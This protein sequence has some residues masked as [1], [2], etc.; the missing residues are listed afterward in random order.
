[1]LGLARGR[2]YYNLLSWYRVLA[3]L[4]GFKLNRR[5]M[6][7]MMG[8][9]EGL[10]AAA[11]RE[12]EASPN[13]RE[14]LRDLLNL[15]RTVSGLVWNHFTLQRQI[16]AFE[17][18]LRRTLQAPPIPLEQM[19]LDE[20]SNYYR[21]L[22][23]ELLL[24][25]DAPLVNDFFAM[26]F[27]GL[28]RDMS[29][30]WVKDEAGT[31]PNDLLSGEGG[32]ISTEPARRVLKMA[33]LARECPELVTAL[34]EG[35][36]RE[37]IEQIEKHPEFAAAY[38]DYL[39][40]FGERCLE[41]LKLETL[42]LTDNPLP[43]L[44]SVGHAARRC[45]ELSSFDETKLR[46]A[47]EKRVSCS[48]KKRFA[49]R[50]L[51]DW[52]LQHARARVKARENLRFERTR[53]F[54][55]VRRIVVEM[56][57]RLAGEGR[58]EEDRDVFYL[59]IEELLGFVEGTA[60]SADLRNLAALRKKE[61]AR[62]RTEP[63]PA[64]RFE[65]TG[66]VYIG[67]RFSAAAKST[68]LAENGQE[69]RGIGCC[70]GLVRGK[71]RVILDPQ[72]A[73]IQPGEILVAPRTDPGWILLFPAAAGLLVEHGS[74]LSHSAIVAREMGIPAIVSIGGLTEWV[75]TGEWLEMDGATGL[76]RKISNPELERS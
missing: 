3:L 64:D 2:I 53:V 19:R 35:E 49:R 4:P 74:L 66:A 27:F 33:G 20:L 56:G 6:E 5:F 43:L 57:R 42:T 68:V 9:K 61:F 36:V 59:T 22:E 11:L 1:M 40:H 29:R 13:A 41:E 28:L 67:N 25:W 39:E 46:R 18:R 30:R 63:A 37:I 47:A 8:V 34:C 73:Q 32:I 75:K 23:R 55:R 21:H 10:P 7:Q 76:M 24:R 16:C 17:A 31:L 45:K 69:L 48:L 15:S 51:F 12:F 58:L 71:A 62:W 65:T 52:V 60:V 54:A 70:P 72:S 38:H 44:R 26:I 14:K 50:V